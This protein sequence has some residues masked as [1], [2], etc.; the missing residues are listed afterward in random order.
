MLFISSDTER[1][2]TIVFQ[3]ICN[4]F[5]KT[6]TWDVKSLAMGKKTLEGLTIMRDALDLPITIEELLHESKTKQEKVFPTA[7]LMPGCISSHQMC[8]YPIK[9]CSL[10]L[11]SY[12]HKMLFSGAWLFPHHL[13]RLN[14]FFISQKT[15]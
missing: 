12:I 3:E 5:G 9:S 11:N 7:A 14:D 1:L 8:A 2:Y 4:R 13:G 10:N 15:H 6:Y